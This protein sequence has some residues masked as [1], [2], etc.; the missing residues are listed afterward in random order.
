MVYSTPALLHRWSLPEDTSEAVE[1]LVLKV[2]PGELTTSRWTQVELASLVSRKVRMGE[3]SASEAEAGTP[4][5]QACA[6][7]II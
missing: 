1:A 7:R 6:G 2:K 5:I 3:L 4:R